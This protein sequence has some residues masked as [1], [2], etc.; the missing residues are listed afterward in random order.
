MGELWRRLAE[1]KFEPQPATWKS[2]L[3]LLPIPIVL[4][5][6]YLDSWEMGCGGDRRRHAALF[7]RY[8]EVRG[9]AAFGY[10]KYPPVDDAEVRSV[11]PRLLDLVRDPVAEVRCYACMSLGWLGRRVE[12]G[13]DRHQVVGALIAAFDDRDERVRDEALGAISG[14]CEGLDC[15]EA[16]QPLTER[17]MS[18]RRPTRFYAI[19]ALGGV[20]TSEDTEAI[21]VLER[22]RDHGNGSEQKAAHQALT[23]IRAR[24][25]P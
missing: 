3:R 16:V 12:G 19:A 10:G 8:D 2:W 6:A 20:A 9:K 11:A 17:A 5:I 13:V 7:S 24:H 14:A 4:A 23:A 1:G 25:R 18:S 15:R 22:L 21:G